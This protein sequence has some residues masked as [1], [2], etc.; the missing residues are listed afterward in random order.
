MV[1]AS[2][3][4]AAAGLIATGK[5]DPAAHCLR[6]KQVHVTN[7]SGTGSVALV[8]A[9]LLENDMSGSLLP[10]APENIATMVLAIAEPAAIGMSPIG[11]YLLP[12]RHRDDFGVFI[13]AGKPAVT[14]V[15]APIS[16]GLYGD[17]CVQAY[18]KL[19]LGEDVQLT[20]PGIMAFDG[21][22]MFKLAAG[23]K[24]TLSVRRD[25]PRIIEPVPIMNAAVAAGVMSSH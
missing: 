19:A 4:G 15:R 5:L 2:V 1:E 13:E 11:G 8:D 24:V 17:V 12:C 23:D 18:R 7:A 3:A 16:A 9:V 6:A 22:R 21:D 10:F 14:Q 20:G 25:G